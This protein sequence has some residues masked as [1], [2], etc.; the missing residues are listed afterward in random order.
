MQAAHSTTMPE[1]AGAL[2]ATGV[3]GSTSKPAAVQGGVLSNHDGEDGHPRA[4]DEGGDRAKA[5]RRDAV[6]NH[7]GGR[8]RLQAHNKADNAGRGK[9]GGVCAGGDA[10]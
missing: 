5:T 3:E 6:G 4:K 9:G 1:G 7:A 10:L 8:R 2:L